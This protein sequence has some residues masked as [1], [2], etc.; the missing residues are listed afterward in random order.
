MNRD[1]GSLSY[2]D[3]KPLRGNF[4][5][6]DFKDLISTVNALH[7]DIDEEKVV[8]FYLQNI[9]R[10]NT[11]ALRKA[12]YDFYGDFY[13]KCRTYFFAKSFAENNPKRKTYFYELTYKSKH[14]CDE[15]TMGICHGADIEFVYGE[16]LRD[17]SNSKVD[18]DFSLEIIKMWTNFAKTG[19]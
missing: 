4:N 13:Y 15:R 16:V 6:K 7:H 2:N 17:K 1:E 11:S 9:D 5:E 19:Y 12:F 14:G 8:D 10:S 3:F 18:I